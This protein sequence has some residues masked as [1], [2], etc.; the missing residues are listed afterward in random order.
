MYIN[1][2]NPRSSSLKN[3]FQCLCLLRDC[4][5]QN[6]NINWLVE[7]GHWIIDLVSTKFY[8]LIP[9]IF[10]FSLMIYFKACMSKRMSHLVVYEYYISS[11]IKGHW[12]ESWFIRWDDSS[13]QKGCTASVGIANTARADSDG[14]IIAPSPTN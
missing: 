6:S 5:S 9:F 13:R 11:L 4:L 2:C 1:F 14:I 8:R 12:L 7:M 10:L 3:L